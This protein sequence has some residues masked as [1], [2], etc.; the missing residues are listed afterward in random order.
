MQSCV[1]HLGRYPIRLILP[2]EI[3]DAFYE[4]A[5][6]ALAKVKIP[7]F[8]LSWKG[9]NHFK[10]S[11]E[12]YRRFSDFEFLL[13]VEPDVYVFRD[14]LAFWCSQGYDYI[15]APWFHRAAAH[16]PP[17]LKRVGNSGFSLRRRKAFQDW[18]VHQERTELLK[19]ELKQ[20]GFW[21]VA[22]NYFQ[23]VA[24][25][26]QVK[27]DPQLVRDL[28]GNGENVQEDGFWCGNTWEEF[29]DSIR[30]LRVLFLLYLPWLWWRLRKP[31]PRKASR[32]SFE[33]NPSYLYRLNRKR[34]PF[35]C[36][37]W[38]KWEPE[39]WSRYIT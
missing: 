28:I 19:A 17:R 4:Q 29:K 23:I 36:H 26:R 22:G 32:F 2:V 6:P 25:L 16:E 9:Y 31:S 24:R 37:A 1:R 30:D 3:D 38:M 18:F 39:F 5:F 15:G 20:H 10:I 8:L 11:P 27:G 33:V 14:E 13:T 7:N 34:L 12:F 21:A 35:G